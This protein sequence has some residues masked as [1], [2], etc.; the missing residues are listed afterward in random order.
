MYNDILWIP[1]RDRVGP[2]YEFMDDLQPPMCYQD[3]FIFPNLTRPYMPPLQYHHDSLD[4]SHTGPDW[5]L[6]PYT[7]IVT[8]TSAPKTP[9]KASPASP[10]K[11]HPDFSTRE[12]LGLANAVITINPFG[13]KHGQKGAKWKE[14]SKALKAEKLFPKSS[15]DTIKNKMIALLKYHKVSPSFF[16]CTFIC[17]CLA[18]PLGSWFCYWFK[19]CSGDEF[20]S[21]NQHCCATQSGLRAKEGGRP[22][23]WRPEGQNQS[24]MC[25]HFW[26]FCRDLW[27]DFQK[28]EKD[29]KGGERAASPSIWTWCT[30]LATVNATVQLNPIQMWRMTIWTQ[31]TAIWSVRRRPACQACVRCRRWW[32]RARAKGESLKAKLLRPCRRVQGFMRQ[33]RRTSLMFLRT[34]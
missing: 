18:C 27:V 2:G 33:H 22:S 31:I 16:C 5:N 14:V 19:D 1:Q 21:W 15:T 8:P 32:R 6:V 12:Y 9:T 25:F 30:L 4:T 11:H 34:S 23:D 20:D 7:P 10:T 28:D 29:H 24:C 13:V 26:W 3:R 17:H